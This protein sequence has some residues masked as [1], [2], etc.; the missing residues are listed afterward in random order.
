M[1]IVIAVVVIVVTV[2][3]VA[4]IQ[5][6]RVQ[7][8]SRR[9]QAEAEKLG[10]RRPEGSGSGNVGPGRKA[11]SAQ[12]IA[13][14][15]VLRNVT[16][17]LLFAQ[18]RSGDVVTVMEGERT[19]NGT[20]VGIA[21]FDYVFTMPQGRYVRHWRQTVIR[22]SS[23]ELDL[24]GFG[25][26]PESVFERM[27]AHIQDRTTRELLQGT[28]GVSFRGHPSFNQMMHV[29]GPNRS[30]VRALFDESVLQFF[31]GGNG[32]VPHYNLCV[33]GSGDALIVYRY[34]R[35]VAPENLQ[36]FMDTAFAVYERFAA[37]S[38]RLQEEA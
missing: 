3:V 25:V 34:D 10:L 38:R 36:L 13:A 14:S 37:A 8:R 33:E 26:M 15:R 22:L 17:F 18:G 5:D 9:L 31:E 12:E 19:H 6:Q 20:P 27:V 32:A 11:P 1:P 7:A 29:Q 35:E 16:H 28:A 24:P 2:L 4:W 23:A 30:Q 21:L